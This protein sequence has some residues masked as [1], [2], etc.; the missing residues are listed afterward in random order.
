[1]QD[2]ELQMEKFRQIYS[3][4]VNVFNDQLDMLIDSVVQIEERLN[5]LEVLSDF[6]KKCVTKYRSSIPTVAST[7]SSISSCV[8]TANNQL[9][10]MLNSPLST[11]NSLQSY[12]TNYFEKEIV[13]CAK[14]FDNVTANYT[15][16][17]TSVV[18]ITIFYI[19]CYKY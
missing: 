19:N 4:R 9:T 6:S 11:K 16:C 8:V 1:M 3:G 15:T 18:G 13:N 17:V 2:Y 12:Y 5:P 14:K 7:K 10:S